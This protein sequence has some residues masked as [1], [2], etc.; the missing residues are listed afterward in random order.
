MPSMTPTLQR[1]HSECYA[2]RLGNGLKVL[3]EPRPGR[4]L[5]LGI[6]ARLGSRD[7]RPERAGISHFLEHMVFKGTEHRTAFQISEEI[8]AIGGYLNAMTSRESTAFHVDVLPQHLDRALE[9]LADLLL[10]PLFKAEDIEREKGVITEEIRMSL[11]TPHDLVF[12]LFYEQLWE[13][14]HPLARP[15]AGTVESVGGLDREALLDQFSLYDAEKIF[16]VAVGDVDQEELMEAA[17][18]HLGSLGRPGGDGHPSNPPQARGGY[19]LESKEI[20]QGHL[21]LGAPGLSKDDPRRFAFE[22]LNVVLGGGMSSRLF[23]RIRE[24]H[25]LAYAVFSSTSYYRD[26]GAFV[27]YLGTDPG[28]APQALEICWEE[29]ERLQREPIAQETLWLA[30]EKIKGNM[31][32]GLESSHARMIRLGMGEVH[33]NHRSLEEVIRDLEAVTADQA[34][35]VARDLFGQQPFALA[36]VGA[37][38]SLGSLENALE[39]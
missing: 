29:I 28:N 38:D 17:E 30:K 37:A 4:P 34:Q 36:V 25:G 18:R 7:E 26:A 5:S 10:T 14:G 21:C 16:L 11:D 9:V 35:Q 12:D 24:D 33:D 6:W 22:V 1:L 8:D 39:R 31:L 13:P 20:Q 19:R 23:K 2:G 32:L 3:F 27:I 15:I